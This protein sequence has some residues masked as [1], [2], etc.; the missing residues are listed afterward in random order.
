MTLNLSPTVRRASARLDGPF[1][2]GAGCLVDVQSAYGLVHGV[3]DRGA[4]LGEEVAVDVLRGLDLAVAH[5]VGDLDVGCAGGD[6]QRGAD[7]SQLVGDVSDDP[8]WVG[9]GIAVR[10]LEVAAPH[11][12][13][14]VPAAIAVDQPAVG[15]AVAAVAAGRAASREAADGGH[16]DV[17]NH[18][19]A[20][21]GAC[22][23]V[24]ADVAA[25]AG[26]AGGAVDVDALLGH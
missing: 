7:V 8:V 19:G 3:E 16:G 25:A 22:L 9:G 1:R 18:D 20:F 11:G 5:L 21:G 10:E 17:G 26:F 23:E 15:G 13:A 2:A 24:L 12:I 14:E 4:V 6:E